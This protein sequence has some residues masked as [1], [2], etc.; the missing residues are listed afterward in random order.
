MTDICS[1]QNS[2]S[3][4]ELQFNNSEKTNFDNY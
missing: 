4:I 3:I 1:N 2:R